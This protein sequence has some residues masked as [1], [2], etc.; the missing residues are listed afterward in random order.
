[1]LVSTS[2]ACCSDG[3]LVRCGLLCSDDAVA[4]KERGCD[5]RAVWM[6]WDGIC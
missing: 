6:G 4:S 5:L 1:M 3:P 2:D